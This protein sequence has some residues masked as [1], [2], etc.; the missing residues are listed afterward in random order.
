MGQQ[1]DQEV[2]PI[3]RA[4][5][6]GQASAA[7][8]VLADERDQGRVIG[9]VIEGVAIGDA[10]DDKPRRTVENGC[11]LR[12]ALSEGAPIGIRQIASQSVRKKTCRGE[13]E[14]PP[15]TGSAVVSS[16]RL[17]GFRRPIRSYRKVPRKSDSDAGSPGAGYRSSR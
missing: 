5:D 13:Q 15:A 9:V 17:S 6:F 14:N 1:G 8:D 7:E 12:L 16:V 3:L 11:I 2:K 10:L 4:D